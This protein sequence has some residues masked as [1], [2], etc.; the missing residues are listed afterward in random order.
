MVS[1]VVVLAAATGD[2]APCAAIP[3]A[4]RSNRVFAVVAALLRR[5][6]IFPVGKHAP[7]LCIGKRPARLDERQRFARFV[8]QVARPGLRQESEGGGTKHHRQRGEP[9]HDCG[10]FLRRKWSSRSCFSLTGLGAPVSRS[11]PRWVFGNAITSR[12]ASAPAIRVTMR[13]KPKAI[14]PCGGAPY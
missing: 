13:S 7:V 3:R 5:Q 11:C 6:E 2:D 12:M 9:F 14:P 1:G 8:R 10:G 4:R